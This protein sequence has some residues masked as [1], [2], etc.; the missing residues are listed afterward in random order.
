M[1]VEALNGFE[2]DELLRWFLHW[3][4]QDKRRAL[5]QRF[6][7]HYNKMLGRELLQVHRSVDL[8]DAGETD[9]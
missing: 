1:D 3:L 2:K 6:P 8:V 7:Q 4:P 5:M 9:G